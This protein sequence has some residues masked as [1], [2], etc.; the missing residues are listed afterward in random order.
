MFFFRS[1]VVGVA[2]ANYSRAEPVLERL[3]SRSMSQ[4]YAVRTGNSLRS[5]RCYGNVYSQK[6][7]TTSAAVLGHESEFE[8]CD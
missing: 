3:F 8:P 4:P 2:W 7:H 5:D 6:F 1:A